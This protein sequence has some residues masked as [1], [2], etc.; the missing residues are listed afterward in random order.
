MGEGGGIVK[1]IPQL[2]WNKQTIKLNDWACFYSSNGHNSIPSPLRPHRRPNFCQEYCT[3]KCCPCFMN[4]V[5]LL[6]MASLLV[7]VAN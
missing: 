1:K 5:C 3:Q 4:F 2:D 6:E 7:S